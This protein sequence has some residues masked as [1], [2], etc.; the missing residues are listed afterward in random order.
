VKALVAEADRRNPSGLPFVEALLTA[1]SLQVMQHAGVHAPIPEPAKGGLSA[2]ARRRVL[3][4]IEAR[5][6]DGL[7]VSELAREAGLSPTHFARAFK[8]SMGRAQHQY[9]LAARFER[10]RR[11]LDAREASL[12]DVALR[13]GFADQAHFTRLFKRH[14]G[15]TPGA[16]RRRRR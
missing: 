7:S 10:A 12:S 15:V 5:L 3:E 4:L 9:I 8:Q 11:M 1:L 16:V 6:A 14:F 13:T 2:A